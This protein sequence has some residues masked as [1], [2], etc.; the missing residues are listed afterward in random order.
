[1]LS[2]EST[3]FSLCSG[4][5]LSNLNN[6]NNY[7]NL[8]MSFIISI[9][10]EF[11]SILHSIQW[12]KRTHIHPP[13]QTLSIPPNEL[14]RLDCFFSSILFMWVVGNKNLCKVYNA[15]KLQTKWNKVKRNT[16]THTPWKLETLVQWWNVIQC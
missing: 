13:I 11:L 2:S 6:I 7:R 8:F 14:I 5:M 12:E 1:M 4:K 3:S 10:K 16:H 15:I 9:E